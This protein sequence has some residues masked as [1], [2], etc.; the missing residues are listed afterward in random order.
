MSIQVEADRKAQAQIKLIKG[1]LADPQKVD[2]YIKSM[3]QPAKNM[4]G[5]LYF[6]LF[7]VCLTGF[8]VLLKHAGKLP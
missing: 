6:I 3:V 1:W 5:A 4:N 2:D 7:I 8:V